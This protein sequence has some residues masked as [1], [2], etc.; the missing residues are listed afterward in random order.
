M[1]DIREDL[2]RALDMILRIKATYKCRDEEL[3]NFDLIRTL[4]CD[5]IAEENAIE[6]WRKRN[7]EQVGSRTV[8]EKKAMT[9]IITIVTDTVTDAGRVEDAAYCSST[10]S[11][12]DVKRIDDFIRETI[13]ESAE[14]SRS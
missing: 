5:R 10:L 13:R 2:H 7:D 3:K 14:R 4:L 8:E 1:T 6:E 12:D 11:G 9:T